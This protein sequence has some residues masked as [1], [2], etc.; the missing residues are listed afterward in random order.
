MWLVATVETRRRWSAAR[1][2]RGWSWGLRSRSE[3]I[4]EDAPGRARHGLAVLHALAG[5]VV[6]VTAE[7]LRD[8]G[9]QH[10]EVR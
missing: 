10:P 6:V 8:R 2:R 7:H 9:R 5:A 4:F 1:L 3:F